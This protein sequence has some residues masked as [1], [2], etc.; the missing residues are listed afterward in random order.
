MKVSSKALIYSLIVFPGSGYFIA[1]NKLRGGISLSISLICLA[2]FMIEAFHKAQTLAEKIIKGEI[3]Y[4]IEVIRQQIPLVSGY[5]SNEFI[6]VTTV[7]IV[8]TWIIATFDSF[9]IARQF[10]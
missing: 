6:T 1:K 2:I 10:D 9:R 3:P 5:F 7:V 8:L 4:D